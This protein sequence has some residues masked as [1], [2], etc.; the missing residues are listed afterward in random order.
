MISYVAAV[1][2]SLALPRLAGSG[3]PLDADS[4]R[5]LEESKDPGFTQK[6]N[7]AIAAGVP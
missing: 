4:L 1:G 7:A 5:F 6:K 3:G 2:P